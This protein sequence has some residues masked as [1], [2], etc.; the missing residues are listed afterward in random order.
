MTYLRS[1]TSA[2]SSI[3]AKLHPNQKVALIRSQQEWIYVE[4]FDYIEAIPK[5]GWVYEKRLKRL[6]AEE[7]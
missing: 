1:Q 6:S 2:K 5:M 7:K 4:Y 3:I